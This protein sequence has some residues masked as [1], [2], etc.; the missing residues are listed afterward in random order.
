[1]LTRANALLYTPTN[2]HFGI[3]PLEAMSAGCPVIAVDSGGPTETVID[4]TTGFLVKQTSQAFCAAMIEILVGACTA[5]T[6][7]RDTIRSSEQSDGHYSLELRRSQRAIEIGLSGTAHVSTNFHPRIMRHQLDIVLQVLVPDLIS[8]GK[9]GSSRSDG[10]EEYGVTRYIGT[11]GAR[12]RTSSNDDAATNFIP[13]DDGITELTK[14]HE[15]PTKRPKELK[16]GK[17]E[18]SGR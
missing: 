11:S 18:G 16:R 3:V 6:S 14:P 1:M 17:S 5:D 7:A 8:Y 13:F 12:I 2:E 15:G 10:G 9:K 4:G